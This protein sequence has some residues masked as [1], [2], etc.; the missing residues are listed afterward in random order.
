VAITSFVF[1]VKVG[2][3]YSLQM[4]DITEYDERKVELELLSQKEENVEKVVS[5]QVQ[6][7]EE[8]IEHE[9]KEVVDKTYT[10]LQEEMKRL[11]IEGE[12]K[13]TKE[14]S[15]PQLSKEE[16]LAKLNGE[17][18]NKAAPFSRT[19]PA[20]KKT[21]NTYNKFQG[22]YTVQLG[23]HRSI[24]DAKKF[25][26]GFKVRGYQPIINEVDIKGRG[27]W[28]RVSLG[29]FDSLEDAKSYIVKESSLFKGTEHVVQRFE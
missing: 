17:M 15:K 24:E 25:A 16:Q 19:E 2:K 6:K 27:T 9:T 22:K 13:Q 8:S 21:V 26:S 5:K 23:S 7:G 11:D 1:G 12:D 29:V 14:S 20:L 4:A 28:Y 18:N 3:R 10:R